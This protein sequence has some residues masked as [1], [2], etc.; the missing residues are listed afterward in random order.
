MH[1]STA[2]VMAALGAGVLIDLPGLRYEVP[3]AGEPGPIERDLRYYPSRAEISDPDWRLDESLLPIDLSRNFS[4]DISK[5]W[6]HEDHVQK[7]ISD[8][9]S[10]KTDARTPGLI[11]NYIRTASLILLQSRGYKEPFANEIVALRFS[12]IAALASQSASSLTSVPD[13][14]AIAG[15][16]ATERLQAWI[17]ASVF[18]FS[19]DAA[20][21]LTDPDRDLSAQRRQ[22]NAYLSLAETAY[23]KA[24]ENLAVHPDAAELGWAAF[25]QQEASAYDYFD[26]PRVAAMDK[27]LSQEE[28]AIA[29]VRFQKSLESKTRDFSAV[30]AGYQSDDP[31]RAEVNRQGQLA[32]AQV[33]GTY[34]GS[35]AIVYFAGKNRAFLDA[36][37]PINAIAPCKLQTAGTAGNT[38]IFE[39]FPPDD[40]SAQAILENWWRDPLPTKAK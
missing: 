19:T 31:E 20:Y 7:S 28:L 15:E 26:R 37:A 33:Y 23:A 39:Y 18:T 35:H 21:I 27:L 30:L 36:E 17:N 32:M 6:L 2:V 16:E 9:D 8:Q 40:F 5:L 34:F 3:L 14:I 24:L 38:L 1:A 11:E 25:R 29:L 4:V 22:Y 13:E 12:E 10:L